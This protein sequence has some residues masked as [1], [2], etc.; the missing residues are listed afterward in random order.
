VRKGEPFNQT[1][2][3]VLTGLSTRT[4]RRWEKGGRL[5][6][7]REQMGSYCYTRE[8]ITQARHLKFFHSGA[9]TKWLQRRRLNLIAIAEES[10]K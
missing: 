8:V 10:L 2:A 3:S 4:L 1:Q 6:P 7:A 9:G 5:R